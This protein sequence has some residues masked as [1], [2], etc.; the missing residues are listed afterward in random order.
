M[1]IQVFILS[2]LMVEKTYPYK[3][4]KQM[5]EP[6]PLD[7]LGG[8]TESKL[9]YHFDA[10]AKKGLIEPVEVIKEEHRPDKQVFEITTKGKEEL[11]KKIY[12]LFKS[13]ND[14]NDIVI[15]LA[16]LKYVDPE[17]VVALLNAR[18]AEYKA[19]WDRIMNFENTSK[20]DRKS[21][22]LNELLV[23]YFT[24]KSDHT[25]YWLEEAII[26]IEQGNL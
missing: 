14:I 5:T 24:T 7:E 11:P 13:A 16:N 12:Q 19:H 2:R 8:I 1:S 4:K 10:L 3:L 20:R 25:I 21:E 23:G 6:I 22:N 18:L 17:K 9:Y 15:G 26:Q